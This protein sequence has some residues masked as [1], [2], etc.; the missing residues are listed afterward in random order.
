MAAGQKSNF[1]PPK[2]RGQRAEVKVTGSR[3]EVRSKRFEIRGSRSVVEVRGPRSEVRD[4]RFEVRVRS[5]RS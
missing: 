4:Q 1:R 5:K 2:I 3:S